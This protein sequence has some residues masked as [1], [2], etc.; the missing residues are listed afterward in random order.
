MANTRNTFGAP[1]TVTTRSFDPSAMAERTVTLRG[2]CAQD[3]TTLVIHGRGVGG[4]LTWRIE[5]DLATETWT[6]TDY[7]VSR[8][9]AITTPSAELPPKLLHRCNL[10]IGAACHAI[11]SQ[12]EAAA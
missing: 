5:Q 7:W 4:A 3:S 6:Y 10:F 12:I 2:S 11:D 8:G 9:C 1:I